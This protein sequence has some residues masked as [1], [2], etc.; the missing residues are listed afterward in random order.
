MV[1][2]CGFSDGVHACSS[3]RVVFFLCTPSVSVIFLCELGLGEQS[4]VGV[5]FFFLVCI[6]SAC[7]VFGVQ[8]CI[9]ILYF[10][11]FSISP[12]PPLFRIGHRTGRA[13]RFKEGSVLI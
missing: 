1:R 13:R 8:Q 12:P 7:L 3:H 10:F 9:C 2:L 11:F 6:L 4:W 5:F